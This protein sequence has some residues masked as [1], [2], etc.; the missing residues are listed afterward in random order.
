MPDMLVRLKKGKTTYEVL[1]EEGK[2][3]KYR[4]GTIKDLSQVIV[5]DVVWI[6]ASKGKRASAEQLN[7]SFGTSDVNT[8]IELIV[9]T[10]DSQESDSERKQKLSDKRSEVIAYITKHYVDSKTDKPIPV[11]RIENALTQTKSKIDPLLPVAKQV[12][13][14]LPKLMSVLSMKK[15]GGNLIGTLSVA[16]KFAGS[17]GGIIRK[18]STVL[19]ENFVRGQC[20]FEV[21]VHDQSALISAVQKV[22]NGE[23]EFFVD[24]PVDT[25]SG[26][27]SVADGNPGGGGKKGKKKGK[28]GGK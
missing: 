23:F 7:S 28:K 17:V 8:I 14:L 10:G 12:T 25:S 21:E 3:A 22:T 11:T 13:T 26:A 1:V 2:V 15:G 5:A 27:G 9:K 16:S 24:N 19:R 18:H 6:N 20:R 4:D